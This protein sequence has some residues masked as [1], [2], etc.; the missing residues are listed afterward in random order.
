MSDRMERGC[1]RCRDLVHSRRFR[2]SLGDGDYAAAGYNP[3]AQERIGG[4][5]NGY[6]IQRNHMRVTE[7]LQQQVQEVLKITTGYGYEIEELKRRLSEVETTVREELNREEAR[8]GGSRLAAL[9]HPGSQQEQRKQ[10]FYASSHVHSLRFLPLKDVQ[11]R[12]RGDTHVHHYFISALKGRGWAEG[13]PE[14]FTFP[15]EDGNST[16][17]HRLLCLRGNSTSDGTQNSYALAHKEELPIGA[18]LVQG[19]T[20]ISDTLWDFRNPWHSMFN[21]VQFIYWRL[22][23]ACTRAQNLVVFHQAEFRTHLGDWIGS[24]LSSS[25]LPSVPLDI[26]KLAAEHPNTGEADD[27]PIMCF[28]RAIVSRRGIGGMTLPLRRRL[29]DE[30]RCQVRRACNIHVNNMYGADAEETKI[31]RSIRHVNVTLLVRQRTRGFIDE[32]AWRRVLQEQCRPTQNCTWSVIYVANMSFC[33][34]VEAMSHTN[35]LISAHGGQLA[36]IVFMSPGGSLM[37]LFPSGWLEM[38]GHGQYIYKNLAYWVGLHHEGFWRDPL[39]PPCPDPSNART[40]FSYY[41]DQPIGIN[42]THITRWLKD[43]IHKHQSIPLHTK[44]H[45]K[46]ENISNFID[47]NKCEC[48]T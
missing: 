47:Q 41:K 25:G 34:Q 2:S 45:G 10:M 4:T 29:F 20:L 12:S 11:A 23:N 37:E 15:A 5:A 9:E 24:V 27:L 7:Q 43:V 14:L 36:N 19:T 28:E 33:R 3:I 38:A 32:G 18:R 46:K 21:L 40:C 8:T 42:T 17:R 35:I 26:N 16:L 44:D 39:T 6:W 48:S 13:P 31:T 1:C 30:M 22:D